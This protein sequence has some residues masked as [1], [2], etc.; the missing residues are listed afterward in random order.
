MSSLNRPFFDAV[1]PVF[2]GKLTQP[3]V[4]GLRLLV[5]EGKRRALP[6][7]QI[8]YVLATAFHET[9]RTM[10]PI[11]EYGGNQYFHDRYDPKGKKPHIA[12]ALG[13]VHRGD[14]VRYPGR[15]HV[16]LTGRRNYTKMGEW[17]DLPLA[18]Q[19]DLALD[20]ET[21]V[22]VIY[23]GMVRG[24]FTGKKMSDYITSTKI[25]YPNARRVVNGKDKARTI[26]GYARKFEA[27]L[28]VAQA[29]TDAPEPKP[30]PNPPEAKGGFV[31]ALLG[32]LSRMLGGKA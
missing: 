1:R 18:E 21:S 2:G 10:Q 5:A 23:E 30:R 12:R 22:K 16:Q 6:K 27:A 32:A 25:D 17:L 26:A 28:D 14:G 24:M 19:P 20:P 7:Q 15:G 4:D 9:A 8:A 31:A 3:Q 29:P 13:N 11:K